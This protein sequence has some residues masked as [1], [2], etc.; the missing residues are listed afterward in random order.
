MSVLRSTCLYHSGSEDTDNPMSLDTGRKDSL[1]LN[2]EFVKVN[3]SRSRK[4][5]VPTEILSTAPS[6]SFSTAGAASGS[7][8]PNVDSQTAANI[9]RFSG[10]VTFLFIT[11]IFQSLCVRS[12]SG[13]LCLCI[14]DVAI[15]IFDEFD[16]TAN[17]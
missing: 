8:V 14:F 15:T 5:F 6:A 10:K 2:V 13:H 4:G 17:V 3:I 16:I 9:V 1:S 7:K 12:K 11:N